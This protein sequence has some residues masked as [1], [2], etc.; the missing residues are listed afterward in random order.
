M[1]TQWNNPGYELHLDG[2]PEGE[3]TFTLCTEQEPDAPSTIGY[4]YPEILLIGAAIIVA[5]AVVIVFARAAKKRR[6]K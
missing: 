6:M 4:V 5:V 3:L 2:L 1:K